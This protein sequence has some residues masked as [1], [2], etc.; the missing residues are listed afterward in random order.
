MEPLLPQLIKL[1]NK[2]LYCRTNPV[3]CCIVFVLFYLILHF[4][5]VKLNFLIKLSWERNATNRR[6]VFLSYLL[7]HLYN[8]SIVWGRCWE[9]KLSR[10]FQKINRRLLDEADSRRWMSQPVRPGVP[11][12]PERTLEWTEYDLGGLSPLTT[13][14][15]RNEARSE[16]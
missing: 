1:M 7:N 13:V 14:H 16:C 2:Y 9:T 3:S 8:I 11:D 15:A 6:T 5:R 12:K 10:G 4:I